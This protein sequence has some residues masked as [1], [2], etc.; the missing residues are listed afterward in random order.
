[1]LDDYYELSDTSSYAC[2]FFTECDQMVQLGNLPVL[3]GL[4]M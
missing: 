4:L 1:M 3:D 2:A